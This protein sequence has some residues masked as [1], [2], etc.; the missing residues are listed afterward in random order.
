MRAALALVLLA[1]A[2][3]G[4][5]SE[6]KP[7]VKP[8]VARAPGK[9]SPGNVSPGKMSYGTIVVE[10]AVATPRGN[11]DLE[12]PAGIAAGDVRSSIL[13]AIGVP[14]TESEPATG[15]ETEFIVREDDGSMIS[16]VQGNE[17]RLKRGERV[18]I[19]HGPETE[20][21]PLGKA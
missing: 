7:A 8:A 4:C 6:S 14:P 16:V 19:I 21:A 5:G 12:A 10:R 13:A 2:L 17:G 9:V 11:G 15:S 20:L 3:A 18:L 1:L